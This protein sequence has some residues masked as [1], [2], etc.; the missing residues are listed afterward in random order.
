MITSLIAQ[1]APFLIVNLITQN[2]AFFLIAQN[3]P[4]FDYEL[5]RP[6]C[7]FL[8]YE[9]NYT[10]CLHI[11]TLIMMPF[12]AWW[13]LFRFF[14][15]QMLQAPKTPNYYISSSIVQMD[16]EKVLM[17]DPPS[18][19]RYTN[20]ACK[21]P[22]DWGAGWAKNIDIHYKHKVRST[23]EDKSQVHR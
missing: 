11:S 23:T 21:G 18:L 19:P 6:E 12:Q 9:L 14:G 5:N 8:D 20:S 10:N 15:G 3:A 2:V 1:N 7:P 16:D 4:S 17:Q 22:S 13:G